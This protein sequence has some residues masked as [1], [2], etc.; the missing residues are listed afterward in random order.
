MT[1]TVDDLRHLIRYLL[2]SFVKYMDSTIGNRGLPQFT[3]R[4]KARK[5]IDLAKKV[6]RWK[7]GTRDISLLRERRLCCRSLSLPSFLTVF[8]PSCPEPTQSAFNANAARFSNVSEILDVCG[9][10]RCQPRG[11]GTKAMLEASR[12]K[13]AAAAATSLSARKSGRVSNRTKEHC[14]V[15]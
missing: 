13:S 3:H 15:R 8:I 1:G 12:W 10:T 14:I 2:S 7:T 9:N 6:K 4:S 11:K 5:M